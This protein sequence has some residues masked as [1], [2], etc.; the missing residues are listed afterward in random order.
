MGL[1]STHGTGSIQIYTGRATCLE[2]QQGTASSHPMAKRHYGDC[3]I[4]LPTA[5]RHSDTRE[6]SY[7]KHG[8]ICRPCNMTFTGHRSLQHSRERHHGN[9]DIEPSKAGRRAV[10]PAVLPG[11]CRCEGILRAVG[12]RRH[13]SSTRAHGMSRQGRCCRNRRWKALVGVQCV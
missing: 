12:V 7:K 13:R 3:D 6:T 5:G 8:D 11:W 4:S 10:M 1:H 2:W 9:D